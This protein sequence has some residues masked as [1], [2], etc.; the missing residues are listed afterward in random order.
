MSNSRREFLSRAGS[1][2]VVLPIGFAFAGCGSD[3][4]TNNDDDGDDQDP[5]SYSG[6]GSCANA[7]RVGNAGTS[8]V[9]TSSCA[10]HT[11]D[12]TISDGN[13]TAPP[14]SGVNGATTNADGHTHTVTLTAADLTAINNGQTVTITSSTVGHA[15]TFAFHRAT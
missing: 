4:D 9:V 13:L 14:S 7:N 10:G 15:H 11:H 2:V 12:F 5:A 1:L 6:G 8:L 3:D